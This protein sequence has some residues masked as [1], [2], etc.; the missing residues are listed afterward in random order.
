ME[1]INNNKQKQFGT[2][3]TKNENNLE[4]IWSDWNGTCQVKF[5]KINFKINFI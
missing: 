3:I 4:E 5:L 1:E 2:I